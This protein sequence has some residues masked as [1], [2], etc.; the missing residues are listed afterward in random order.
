L[1]IRCKYIV[2]KYNDDKF[3][4]FN[5]PK[6]YIGKEIMSSVPNYRKFDNIELF[7]NDE[8]RSIKL[9]F[10]K[11]D[12]LIAWEVFSFYFDEII[13]QFKFTYND[14]SFFYHDFAYLSI[15]DFVKDVNY[16]EKT[17]VNLQDYFLY[18]HMIIFKIVDNKDDY[19]YFRQQLNDNNILY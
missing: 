12:V 14:F 9:L 1:F 17:I 18:K 15:V 6:L 4:M 10:K 2:N 13:S 16:F 19:Y 5:K 11:I 3:K 7:F 8:R